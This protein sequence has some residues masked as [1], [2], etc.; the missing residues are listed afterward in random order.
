MYTQEKWEMMFKNINCITVPYGEVGYMLN[1]LY[2]NET[3]Q[4]EA[5][6]PEQTVPGDLLN[7]IYIRRK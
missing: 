7:Y 6:L 5:L 3:R 2:E 1:V 4:L